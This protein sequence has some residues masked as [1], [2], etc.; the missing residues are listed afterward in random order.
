MERRKT[1]PRRKFNA[2]ALVEAAK[3]FE[4]LEPKAEGATFGRLHVSSAK[5]ES[6]EFDSESEFLAEYRKPTCVGADYSMSCGFYTDEL[7]RRLS[8]LYDDGNTYISVQDAERN[9][10]F[11]VSEVFER[12]LPTSEVPKPKPKPEPE[13]VKIFIGHGHSGAWRDLKDHLQDKHEYSVHAYEIGERA[14]HSVRDILEDMLE[15]STIA[16]VVMT[17]EDEMLDGTVRP[18]QNVVHETGLFQGR[19]GFSRCIAVVEEGI[20]MFSNL[21]GVEQIRFEKGRITETFGN[22][23]ATLRREFP[24]GQA[25]T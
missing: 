21:D 22:V 12:H 9:N 5:D 8:I 3:V 16:L 2:D 11:L 13:P 24:P 25:A 1:Y 23:L 7:Y 10:I 15:A 19:L 20:E 18:R 4:Q 14:G 17:A 6:W